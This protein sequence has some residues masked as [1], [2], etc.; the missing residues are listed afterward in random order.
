MREV[1]S[2]TQKP[3][4]PGRGVGRDR[5]GWRVFTGD[6]WRG[7]GGNGPLYRLFP[8]EPQQLLRARSGRSKLHPEADS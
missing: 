8:V 6:G 2:E 7:Q 4:S 5:F 1:D 3:A